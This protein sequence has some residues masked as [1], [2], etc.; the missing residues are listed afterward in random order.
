M[1]CLSFPHK[2]GDNPTSAY[3]EKMG[4][5]LSFPHKPGDNP[6]R[7]LQLNQPRVLSFPHKPGDNP[8]TQTGWREGLE[9]VIPP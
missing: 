2:P 6:T 9:P 1:I 4:F 7:E 8:T 3:M 5:S